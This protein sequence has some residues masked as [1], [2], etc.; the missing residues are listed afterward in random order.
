M[1]TNKTRRTEIKIETH[2]L[3]VVRTGVPQNLTAF[4]EMCGAPV[5]HFSVYRAAATLGLSETAISGLRK[6]AGCIRRKAQPVRCWF[7]AIRFRLWD[8]S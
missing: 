6:A 5:T 1:M 2:E 7:A 4:C 3:T 8:E